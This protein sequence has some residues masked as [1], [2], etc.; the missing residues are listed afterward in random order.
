M[1]FY[2]KLTKTDKIKLQI[3]QQQTYQTQTHN[4]QANNNN[5]RIINKAI[6]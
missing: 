6:P 4:T 3:K 1:K 5:S 2:V